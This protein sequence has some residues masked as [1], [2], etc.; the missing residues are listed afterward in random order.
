MPLK[1]PD[2]KLILSFKVKAERKEIE[3]SN[4]KNLVDFYSFTGKAVN[5]SHWKWVALKTING[6][7]SVIVKWR[8]IN[9]NENDVLILTMSEIYNGM[10]QS[11]SVSVA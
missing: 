5:G 11:N 10:L 8:K 7:Q 6:F 4:G 1:A 9:E 2:G 3:F